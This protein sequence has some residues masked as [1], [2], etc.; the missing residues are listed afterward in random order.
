MI[1]DFRSKIPWYIMFLLQF[2]PTYYST[3]E[4]VT[5]CIKYLFGK[6]YVMS[7]I[8]ADEEPDLTNG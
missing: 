5:L 3:D 8:T 7:E 2:K 4:R 1:T 6:T